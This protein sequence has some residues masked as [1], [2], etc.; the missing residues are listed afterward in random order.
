MTGTDQL[1]RLQELVAG[2]AGASVEVASLFAEH[3]DPTVR[4]LAEMWSRRGEEE[5]DEEPAEAPKPAIA[6]LDLE[7]LGLSGSPKV[8]ALRRRIEQLELELERLEE[9]NDTLAAALGACPQCWGD[10]SR[11]EVCGGHGGPGSM[12]PDRTLFEQLVAPALRRL[13]ELHKPAGRGGRLS[14]HPLPID[15]RATTTERRDV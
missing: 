6:A 4:L 13:R 10:D 2:G 7:D 3:P 11:C 5:G 15:D 8:P 14:A 12:R 1:A 9:I